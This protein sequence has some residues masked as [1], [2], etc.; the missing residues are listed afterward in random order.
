MT[1][2]PDPDSPAPR[3]VPELAPTVPRT[4]SA[5]HRRHRRRAGATAA[6]LV[7]AGLVIALLA[8]VLST[9]ASAT[10]VPTPTTAVPSGNRAH[11]AGHRSVDL[12]AATSA[13]ARWAPSI[14]T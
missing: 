8:S 4:E 6:A 11:V 10:H 7:V 1:A 13:P 9:S 12:A 3:A 14:C 2:T 5:R